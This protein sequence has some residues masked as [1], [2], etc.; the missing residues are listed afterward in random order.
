LQ[1]IAKAAHVTVSTKALSK[2]LQ[3]QRTV[4]RILQQIWHIK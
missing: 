2:S 3:C 1:H 4:D